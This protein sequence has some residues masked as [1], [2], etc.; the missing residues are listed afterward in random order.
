MEKKQT[1]KKPKDTMEKKKTNGTKK[2][3]KFTFK[4]PH[5]KIPYSKRTD[6]KH[7]ISFRYVPKPSSLF[8]FSPKWVGLHA[9]MTVT[10]VSVV[11]RLRGWDH[12]TF[13]EQTKHVL[14]LYAQVVLP[15]F[16][17]YISVA[18]FIMFITRRRGRK[19]FDKKHIKHDF[20]GS[21]IGFIQASPVIS[22]FQGLEPVLSK[23]YD[24]IDGTH[25][26][27]YWL[28]SIVLWFSFEDIANYTV[29]RCFHSKLLYKHFHK[30]HHKSRPP[31]PFAGV[32][33]HIFELAISVCLFYLPIFI[34]PIHRIT[35][36][37]LPGI[38]FLWSCLIHSPLMYHPLPIFASP[39]EHNIHH[40]YGRK[41]YNFGLYFTI[42]DHVFGTYKV[43]TPRWL[44]NPRQSL[45]LHR[46]LMGL[47]L[48]EH[49]EE[50]AGVMQAMIF[51]V[52]TVIHATIVS[53]APRKLRRRLGIL[54][55]KNIA[56][57]PLHL[58]RRLHKLHLTDFGALRTLYEF[59]S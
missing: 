22:L 14:I 32:C 33:L 7:T 20:V 46:H 11:V 18:G 5:P 59:T 2:A 10:I 55:P 57:A 37:I 41:N 6:L 12:L 44:I 19:W 43:M 8:S 24:G 48:D 1:T 16:P 28:F 53:A 52:K 9:L 51:R 34:F 29:H 40:V 49:G 27:L 26:W 17:M 15:F 42:W 39:I 56:A 13:T 38:H 30:Y 23:C 47:A 58:R 35:G 3:K 50:R 36:Y 31:T 21:C 25:G 45:D 54:T 4:V